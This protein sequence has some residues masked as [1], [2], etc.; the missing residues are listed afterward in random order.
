M[1]TTKTKSDMTK[2]ERLFIGELGEYYNDL[3]TIDSLINSRTAPNQA[4]SL[5]CAKLQERETKIRERV[6]YLADKRGIS[7]KE[8]WDQLLT[9]SYQ[10]LNPEEYADLMPLGDGN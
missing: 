7:F 4:N 8:M 1:V 6:Q 9:G 5:L 10:K 2:R 3:L